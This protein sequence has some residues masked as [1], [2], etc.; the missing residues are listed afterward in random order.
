MCPISDIV[1]YSARYL[2]GNQFYRN[3]CNNRLL[4]GLCNS[5]STTILCVELTPPKVLKG[6]SWMSFQPLTKLM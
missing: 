1:F 4:Y 6:A 3:A 5:S 2:S